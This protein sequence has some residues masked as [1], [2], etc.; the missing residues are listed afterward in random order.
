MLSGSGKILI[1]S[2]FPTTKDTN[3]LHLWAQVQQNVCLTF[4]KCMQRAQFHSNHCHRKTLES[5]LQPKTFLDDRS[6]SC[7]LA[8]QLLTKGSYKAGKNAN[9]LHLLLR[10]GSCRNVVVTI[11]AQASCCWPLVKPS[12]RDWEAWFNI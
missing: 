3:N 5:L 1:P 11:S 7:L 2:H 4:A 12:R 10:G 8:R 6:S 9:I